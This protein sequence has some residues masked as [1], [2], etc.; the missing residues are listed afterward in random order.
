MQKGGFECIGIV[1]ES[2][3]QKTPNE[4]VKRNIDQKDH[5]AN[6]FKSAESKGDFC[7]LV[8]G[9]DQ[10]QERQLPSYRTLARPPVAIVKVK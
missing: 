6:G 10:G 7:V 3:K 2:G 5:D 4:N 1:I 8:K 9:L